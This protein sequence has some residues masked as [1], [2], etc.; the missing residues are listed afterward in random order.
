MKYL[1]TPATPPDTIIEQT[2]IYAGRWYL[3]EDRT[4]M[5]VATGPTAEKEVRSA[6]SM[7]DL[8][9]TMGGVVADPDHDDPLQDATGRW[10]RAYGRVWRYWITTPDALLDGVRQ[11]VAAA[12]A[13][14]LP[15]DWA[16]EVAEDTAGTPHTVCT[17]SMTMDQA[18]ALGAQ[19]DALVELAD[20][21]DDVHFFQTV[22]PIDGFAGV[23]KE[24][25]QPT[26]LATAFYEPGQLFQTS[27]SKAAD[28]R[29][30]AFEQSDVLGITG[31]TV[32]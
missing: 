17:F 25:W 13:G 3:V 12:E 14:G 6:A 24:S 30:S 27:H 11:F 1:L 26:T 28:Q 7:T 21:P 19:Q 20:L 9:Q 15:A 18:R 22:S 23:E 2:W 10:Q 5:T 8:A 4:D 29:G 32:Q 31:L 16:E